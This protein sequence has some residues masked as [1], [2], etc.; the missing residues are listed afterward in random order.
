MG[1]AP[2]SSVQGSMLPIDSSGR[3]QAVT[4]GAPRPLVGGKSTGHFPHVTPISGPRFRAWRSPQRTLTWKRFWGIIDGV[5]GVSC[6]EPLCH[7]APW[8]QGLVGGS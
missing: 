4:C 5:S 7:I 1:R 3:K 2:E 6:S 8:Y